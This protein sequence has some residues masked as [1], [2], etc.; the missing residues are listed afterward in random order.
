M[1]LQKSATVK[2]IVGK[3]N[4]RRGA[5]VLY[6]LGKSKSQEIECRQTH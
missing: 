5:Q 2:M 3:E 4:D 1:K 6:V